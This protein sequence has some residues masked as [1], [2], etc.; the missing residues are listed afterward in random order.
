LGHEV[1]KSGED[2]RRFAVLADG[3]VG[4]DPG[5]VG[6]KVD[7][8]WQSGERV[9]VRLRWRVGGDDMV[10]DDGG[11]L[12][13]C[14][15][16]GSVFKVEVLAQGGETL[17][18]GKGIRVGRGGRGGAGLER[19]EEFEL[20]VCFAEVV[21]GAGVLITLEDVLAEGTLVVGDALLD[22]WVEA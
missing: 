10:G 1:R 14:D 9:C 12:G 18:W 20:L 8:G 3:F 6:G 19:A 13:V 11:M 4:V 5:E 17:V 2:L 22:A 16:N 15:G 21:F 7:R